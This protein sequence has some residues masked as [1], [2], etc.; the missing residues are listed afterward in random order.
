MKTLF[1]LTEDDAQHAAIESIGR[2]L[3]EDEL[4]HVRK[5]LESGLECWDEVMRIAIADATRQP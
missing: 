3:T 4:H 2:T 1:V 5:G